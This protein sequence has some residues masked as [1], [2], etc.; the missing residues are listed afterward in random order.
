MCQEGIMVL[1]PVQREEDG[2]SSK[3]FLF[4]MNNTEANVSTKI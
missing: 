3:D 4:Q 2:L 1:G